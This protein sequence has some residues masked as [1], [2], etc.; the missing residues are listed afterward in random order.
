MSPNSG[1]AA[2]EAASTYLRRVDELMREHSLADRLLDAVPDGG[3]GLN[4]LQT[5]L[6]VSTL[7]LLGL[8]EEAAQAR[9]LAV[10]N[11]DGVIWVIKPRV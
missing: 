11:R 4:T 7:E 2:A 8:V 9:L 6:G 10:E 3:A 5:D 1:S